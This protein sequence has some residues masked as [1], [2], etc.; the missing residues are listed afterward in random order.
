MCYDLHAVIVHWGST[1]G[2]GHY[3]VYI[4]VRPNCWR[5]FDDATVTEVSW[6]EV[7]LLQAYLLI[8]QCMQLLQP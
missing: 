3:S 4:Q 7:A 2:S 5:H 6:D 8:Y 1:S